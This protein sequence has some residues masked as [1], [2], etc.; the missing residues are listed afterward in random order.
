MRPRTL[1]ALALVTA[2]LAALALGCPASLDDRCSEG[3]CA[4][5]AGASTDAGA[6]V[7]VTLPPG[8][9]VGQGPKD[10]P[11]CVDD[12][13][14]VF[15]SDKGDDNHAGTQAAPVKTIAAAVSLASASGKP[16]IYVCP[17]KYTSSVDLRTAT[18]L[19][20][21]LACDWKTPSTERPAWTAASP[22]FA[23]K[24]A[25]VGSP[26]TVEDFTIKGVDAQT[27]GQSSIAVLVADTKSVRFT[28]VDITAGK[29]KA[30]TSQ[31][32][33]AAVGPPA[34]PQQAGGDSAP[35]EPGGSNTCPDGVSTGGTG[36]HGG[37]S[38]P[39]ATAGTPTRDGGAPGANGDTNCAG[40]TGVGK[41]GGPGTDGNDGPKL[42][43]PG[44]L[45]A[46]G[47]T[48]ANGEPGGGG[49]RAQGGGGGGANTAAGGAGGAGGCGGAGG[50]GGGGGGA[51]VA[52]AA[53]QTSIV[54][55]TCTLT[56]GVAGD[57]GNGA[58]G[59]PGQPG[60]VGGAGGNSP[61]NLNGCGGGMG[62]TGGAGG[63][64]AGGAAGI[65]PAILNH[66]ATVERASTTLVHGTYGRPGTG[67]N[68]T[69][70]DA[71]APT[72]DDEL[73]L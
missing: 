10:S 24:I 47:F 12:T 36:A 73:K 5:R 51:S 64:G 25:G 61:A 72:Q 60:A 43:T 9:T 29:G 45:A 6:D 8:C 49:L 71:P 57:G 40:G 62:G 22:G 3:A 31:T 14:A 16:H 52:L 58:P 39:L 38:L 66:G 2:P 41:T 30:G 42:T 50:N 23:L 53:F 18:S 46:T 63:A 32:G 15:V 1:F 56:S 27:D 13:V 33:L 34:K 28:R 48:P 21:G 20:G 17:G 54:L 35:G 44:Q 70:N 69:V 55:D 7:T 11:A 4:D 65:A 59:Q 67:G 19:F 37:G 68:P 26:V